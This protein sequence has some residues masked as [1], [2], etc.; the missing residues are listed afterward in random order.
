[1]A[2]ISSEDWHQLLTTFLARD[3]VAPHQL[4]ALH[5]LLTIVPERESTKR[6]LP[7]EDAEERRF[8]MRKLEMHWRAH[9]SEDTGLPQEESKPLSQIVIATIM[10]MD[11]ATLRR[12]TYDRDA[13]D[14]ALRRLSVMPCF[15]KI[16]MNKKR[17]VDEEALLA[18]AELSTSTK[19]AGTRRAE[20]RS[21]ESYDNK[22]SK[23]EVIRDRA[24]KQERVRLD[25]YRCVVLHTGNAEV[26]HIVPF[27]VNS[28]EQYR[29]KMA[30]YFPKVLGSIFHITPEDNEEMMD[31]DS[32][33]SEAWTDPLEKLTKGCR[34]IFTSKAG[35]SDKAWNEISLNCQL[36]KWWHK[37]FFA[38]EPLG[39]DYE[40]SFEE[41][42][43]DV[44]NTPDTG[45]TTRSGTK[46]KKT[47]T[48]VKLQ[49]HW[50]PRRKD[51]G[52]EAP[53]LTTDKASQGREALESMLGKTYGDLDSSNPIFA[54]DRQHS[55]CHFLRTGD[56]FY[57]NVET[58]RANHML[59]AF[60]LQWACIKIFSIAGGAEALKDVGDD[61]DYLDE[62]LEWIGN[63]R[64]SIR[65]L[66]Q[67][68]D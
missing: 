33:D 50:M 9:F 65:E 67:E 28:K 55:I 6:L 1:M 3:D 54:H 68:W 12:I 59:T 11:L 51:I 66:L 63:P 43:F 2:S 62:N 56:I 20:Q 41:D 58:R 44:N 14:D 29:S 40:F 10:T 57:V 15:I 49:F 24:E 23:S 48:R 22:D 53:P 42:T 46:K 19:A 17:N 25:G 13:R 35:I 30:K 31:I 64:P 60:K 38:L 7:I 61:P 47:F 36:R 16:M 18:V 34:E 8:C 45:P 52:S 37:G 32:E 39:I 27:S 26:C 21:D 5:R 4:D